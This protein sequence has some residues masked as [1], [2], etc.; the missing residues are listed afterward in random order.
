M[1][2]SQDTIIEAK[3][4]LMVSP[5]SGKNP[6]R[7]TAYFIKPCVE[8]PANLPPSM[9]SSGRTATVISDPAKLPLEVR[10]NG[11]FYPHRE[12]NIWVQQMQHKY[13]YMWIQAGID[14]AIKAS[15]YQI[16]RSDEL[17]LELAYRWCS[18][19]NTFVFPWGEATITLEDM[20]VCWGYSVMGLPF[21]SPLVSDEEKEVEQGLIKVY[22]EFFKSKA[23]RANHNPWMRYFMSNESQLEHEAFLSL[24]LSRFVFPGRSCQTILKS[25]FPIA[26]HLARGTKLALAPAL[27]AIIYRDLSLLNNK[28]RIVTT[29]ELEVILWAPFQ[30]VQVWALER[31]P[32]LQPRPYVVE[33]GQLLMAKWHSVKMVKHANMKL[34]LDSSKGGNGFIWRPYENSPPLQL[35][36]EN[37][38]WVCKNPNFDDELESFARCLRV[39]ELV[40]I[41]CIEQYCPN[42][43]AMQLGMDQDIPAMLAPR[44][45]NP[46]ICY[47]QPVTDTNLYI[48]FCACNQPNVTSRYY[49]WW[50]QSNSSKQG[51]KH[52]DFVVSSLE[53]V[54]PISVYMNKERSGSYGPPPGFTSKIK[55]KKV[56]FDEMGKGSIVELSSCSSEGSCLGDEEVENGQVLSSP[57]SVVF[58]SLSAEK[59]RSHDMNGVKVQSL[60]CDRGGVS[61][62]ERKDA[63]P[64]VEEVA[65]NLESRVG[66]LVRVIGELK[67]AKLGH[68]VQNIGHNVLL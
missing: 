40:G 38:R 13:E 61:D 27:L 17:I 52:Y 3:E 6:V 19:T 41:E 68:K 8:D 10:Y 23:K 20:K 39:S 31:F 48:A 47:S 29:L 44:K 33:Q 62:M 16:R 14:Q 9:F 51:R 1:E 12:W 59:A 35:Y 50:K 57:L 60:F 42:R 7:R 25:V 30:L 36:D 46:W 2:P 5:L 4:E 55:K 45:E 34:I 64:C 43:V 37:G 53:H 63:S 15:T 54:I 66:K 18:K 22:R 21:S 32:A 49:R 11:W 56:D 58:P 67:A 24:W 26:I 28:I 65:S